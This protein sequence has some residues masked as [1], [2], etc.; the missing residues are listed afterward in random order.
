MYMDI[1]DRKQSEEA[2]RESEERYRA[3]IENTPVGFFQSTPEGRYL[4]VNPAMARIYGYASPAEMLDS[5][6]DIA[7]QIHGDP[8]RRQNFMR[9]MSER[10]EV[11]EF[12]NQNSRKDGSRIYVSTNARVVK[13]QAGTILYYEGFSTDITDRKQS[14]AALRDSESR[15]RS[16]IER[17]PGIVYSFSNQR[18]GLYYSPHVEAVLGYTPDELYA[19][20]MLW[21]DSIHPDDLSLVDGSIRQIERGLVFQIEYRIRDVHGNWRWFDDRSFYNL[22]SDA[23]VI[24]DGLAMDITARKRAEAA[25]RESQSLYQSLV[26]VSPLSICRKDLAGRFTFANRRFL[27]TSQVTLAD[28]VGKTDFD[29]HPPELAEKYRRDDQAV[30]DSGQA[31]EFIE[32]RAV[33][34]GGSTVI[35]SYKTPIY[36]GAG[37]LNGVQISFWDITARK[38]AEDQLRRYEFIA[39]AATEFMTLI[40]RQHVFEAVNDAYCL[41]QGRSR[42][43]LIGRSLAE[44]W[45]DGRYRDKILPYVEQCFAGQIVRYEDTFAFDSGEERY[46]QVGMYPYA[47]TPG[48]PVTYAAIVTVDVTKRVRAEGALRDL[49]LQLNQRLTEQTALLKA[50]AAISSSL[51]ID[52]ILQ[53]VAEHMGMAL[54]V[55]STYICGWDATTG[56]STVLAEWLGADAAPA[57][58]QSSLGKMYD[59][60][61]DFGSDLEHWLFSDQPFISQVDDPQLYEPA[62][63]HMLAYGGQSALTV[64]LVV[65]SRS[66]GYVDLW[67]SRARREFGPGEIALAQGIARQAAVAMDNA[68]LYAELGRHA[69]ELEERVRQRTRQLSEAN[70]QLSELDRMKD[71]FIS[72]ISHELR[73]PLTSVKIYLELLET[74][75]P[76]KR[77]KYMQVL[78]EQANRLQQLIESLLEVTQKSFNAAGLHVAPID[79]NHLAVSLAASA[80]PRAAERGLAVNCRLMDSLPLAAADGILLSQAL[81]HLVTNALNYTPT[82]GSI[83]LVTA[84]VIDNGEDWITFTVRDTGPGIA[85]DELPRIFERFYRGRAA[86]DYKTSGAGVG[87]TI[88]R[89][90]LTALNGRLTVNSQPGAGATFTAWLRP[91]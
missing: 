7:T 35:Q 41:A 57:E 53:Q 51:E 87:L 38:Q 91:A 1:T 37:N 17:M 85:P 9:L 68:R 14:E 82:G 48:G 47:P 71:D 3:I 63:Q 73:T 66:I 72:R 5:V 52:T 30:I 76:E 65:K 4:N 24:I 62:R 77:A 2:L 25:L 34:G 32:E 90:I 86:A 43:E 36:D 33:L 55:T 42:A 23:E 19:H 46:Y 21:H 64:P 29:L 60:I 56:R 11:M 18:G 8:A 54:N 15:Y 27:E 67:E 79:L 81:S 74:G 75:K 70:A 59:L 10:G 45:G 40:N 26:E 22:Q 50:T 13:D 80:T 69:E 49:N 61:D 89:D 28:L 58:K 39:N 6:T 31:Q 44:V 78:T 20:P 12:I 16:L 88:S 83:E 84:Q